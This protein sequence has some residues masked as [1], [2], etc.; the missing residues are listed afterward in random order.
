MSV[1]SAPSIWKSFCDEDTPAARKFACWP[2][3]LPPTLTRSTITPG[4]CDR[5]AHG[6]RA[7][8]IF[9][10]STWLTLVPDRD[11]PLVQ[12]RT[13][14]GDGDRLLERRGEGQR[15]VRVLAETDDDIRIL[16][17]AETVEFRDDCVAAG[18]ETEE[19]EPARGIRELRT[20]RADAADRDANARQGSAGFVGHRAVQIARRGLPE[21]RPPDEQT[22]DDAERRNGASAHNVQYSL[23]GEL[24]GRVERPSP[25]AQ[26]PSAVWNEPNRLTNRDKPTARHVPERPEAGHSAR[27]AKTR[28]LW[29]G[30]CAQRGSQADAKM[31]LPPARMRIQKNGVCPFS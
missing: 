29:N 30:F 13:L 4:V 16:D 14:G 9:S 1:I 11:L 31:A 6:S 10:S 5:T 19:P 20:V 7:V 22:K 25:D 3:S 23:Q 17:T 27:W 26:R 21:G 28:I 12:Q 18:I 15:H 24:Y 2:D 8:G